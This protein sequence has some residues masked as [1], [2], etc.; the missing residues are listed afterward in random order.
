MQNTTQMVLVVFPTISVFLLIGAILM[1]VYGPSCDNFCVYGEYNV[2]GFRECHVN[3]ED[4]RQALVS[5]I[6]VCNAFT[7]EYSTYS[8]QHVNGKTMFGKSL[9]C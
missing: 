2:S 6:E 9:K 5:C 4:G 1:S 7:E 3:F 8:Q